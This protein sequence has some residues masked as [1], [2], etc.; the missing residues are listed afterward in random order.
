MLSLDSLS[1]P[2]VVKNESR[3][4]N[5]SSQLA[6]DIRR[7]EQNEAQ[8]IRHVSSHV[9]AGHQY[10]SPPQYDY[11]SSIDSQHFISS[12][13]VSFDTSAIQDNPPKTLAKALLIHA[14]ALAPLNL[15]LQDISVA[16]QASTIA[17]VA[18]VAIRNANESPIGT[19]VDTLA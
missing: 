1:H 5:S 13:E 8:I 6:R 4:I 2:L 12:G 11:R 18:R 7:F 17:Q 19:Q 16:Q 3:E 9:A 10:T 15:S 14:A